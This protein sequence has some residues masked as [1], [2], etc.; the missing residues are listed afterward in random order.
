[1]KRIPLTQGKFALV[2][3][4]DSSFVSSFKWCIKKHGRTFYA[5]YSRH[6]KPHTTYMHV[7]I[8]QPPK[9]MEI[10]HI[11]GDGLNNQR[12]NLRVCTHAENMKNSQKRLG[13]KSGFKRVF[14]LKESGRWSASIGV[15]G[16]RLHLGHFL[17]K[18]KAHEAYL[19]ACARYHGIYGKPK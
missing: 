15:N 5:K 18:E 19:R 6:K 16:K 8:M 17:S 2:D 10:D 1:M 7:L 14:F 12:K 13:N 11:D 9:G 3:D 4:I